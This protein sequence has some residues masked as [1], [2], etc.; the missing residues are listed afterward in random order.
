MKSIVIISHTPSDNTVALL[1]ALN[2]G[3]KKADVSV[4]SKHGLDVS[5]K[6]VIESDGVLILTT[7][8]LGYMSGIIKDVFDR[9]YYPCLEKTQGLPFALVIRAGQDG[10]GTE[11]AI[12][13]ITTG[14]KWRLSIPVL[15]C[16]GAWQNEFCLQAENV[17]E[18]FAT[19]IELGVF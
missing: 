17:A 16:N 18:T 15:T 10:T 1:N 7:E 2:L 6:D 5:A 8:N 12:K 14:L 4:I 19:G 3:C 13:S 11:R 9:L